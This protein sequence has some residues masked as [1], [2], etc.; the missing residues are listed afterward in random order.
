MA[1][2]IRP[3]YAGHKIA[4]K[5]TKNINFIRAISFACDGGIRQ[6]IYRNILIGCL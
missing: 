3:H 6:R 5:K 2:D 4:K 1:E